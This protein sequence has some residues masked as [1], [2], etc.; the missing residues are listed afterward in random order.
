MLKLNNMFEILLLF[1]SL[2]SISIANLKEQNI[3]LSFNG[4]QSYTVV[5]CNQ[6]I[7]YF[8]P[9]QEDIIMAQAYG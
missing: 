2:I 3:K 8:F 7:F 6:D 5:V 9:G 4:M 1:I